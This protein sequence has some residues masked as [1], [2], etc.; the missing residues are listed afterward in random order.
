MINLRYFTE[1][2]LDILD[3]I[4]VRYEYEIKDRLRYRNLP[5]S[6]KKSLLKDLAL[7]NQISDHLHSSTYKIKEQV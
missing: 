7:V 2:Q 3:K 1:D 5:L 6:D 4:L